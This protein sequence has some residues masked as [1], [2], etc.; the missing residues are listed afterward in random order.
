M[1]NK[2][3]MKFKS[4]F[5]KGTDLLKLK[6]EIGKKQKNIILEKIK[7]SSDLLKSKKEI[8]KKQKDKL[9]R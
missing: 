9:V 4:L 6:T 2:R 1:L 5:Q 8:G 3:L 7:A